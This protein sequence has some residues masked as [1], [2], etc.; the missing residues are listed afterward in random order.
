MAFFD[1]LFGSKT[2]SKSQS[3]GASR[4]DLAASASR[5]SHVHAVPP[6]PGSFAPGT[7]LRFDP[8]LIDRLQSDHRELLNLFGAI[9][10]AGKEG[11]LKAAE[12]YLE[13]FRKAITDHLLKENVSLYVY[14]E[15]LTREDPDSLEIMRGFRREMDGIG[16]AVVAFLGKYKSIGSQ[17]ELAP[18]FA[19]DLADVGKVLGDRIRREESTLYPMYASVS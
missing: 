19:T 10:K 17:P 7:L 4:A 9:S 1:F 3:A 18:Y 5:E 14:L 12:E 13:Q 8:S 11:N 16:R 6:A 15:R 2:K